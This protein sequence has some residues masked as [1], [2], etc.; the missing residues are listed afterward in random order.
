MVPHACN[1]STQEDHKFKDSLD[2]TAR[3]YVRTNK[4]RIREGGKGF[5]NWKLKPKSLLMKLLLTLGL[6]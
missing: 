5:K 6:W 1:P 4:I 3:P 2:Y